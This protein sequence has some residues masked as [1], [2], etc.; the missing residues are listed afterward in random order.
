MKKLE[1]IIQPHRLDEVHD[2]LREIGVTGMTLSEV[3]NFGGSGSHSETYHGVTYAVDFV[4]TV[5]LEIVVK[6]ALVA[7]AVQTLM[8]AA[9]TGKIDDGEI[10]VTSIDETVRIRTGEQ[11]DDAV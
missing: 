4:P 1:A 5:H 9:R 3:R 8:A 2:R 11:G 6:D 7:D 10:F